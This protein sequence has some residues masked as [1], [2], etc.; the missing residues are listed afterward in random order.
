M[1]AD[2]LNRRAAAFILGAVTLL[3]AGVG[4]ALVV[5]NSRGGGPSDELRASDLRAVRESAVGYLRRAQNRD[6]GFGGTPGETSDPIPTAWAALGLAG[7]QQNVREA[8][9]GSRSVE[10]YLERNSPSPK[11][12]GALERSIL[13]AR[14]AGVPSRSLRKQR[15]FR[16]LVRRQASDGSF[17]GLTN[18][19]AFGVLALRAAGEPLGSKRLDRARSWLERQQNSHGGFG[20]SPRPSQ[21]DVDNTAAALQALVTGRSRRTAIDKA[22]H[23]LVRAQRRDGG[24]GQRPG[25]A[26]NAQSTSWAVQGLATGG[27]GR[28]KEAISKGV[29]YLTS[30]QARDGSIR[31]SRRSAQTP[32]WVTGQA[33]LALHLRPLPLV[34]SAR[35][36]QQV[37]RAGRKPLVK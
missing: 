25:Q 23:F 29:M 33:L 28:P 26:S 16:A 10:D 19:T 11:D 13:V 34:G 37:R 6:G 15:P 22:V 8:P 27:S 32:V 31:Y 1:H 2:R 36:H 7:A 24:F 12:S 21:S 18:L 5:L 35:I 30:L 3:L 17:E 20:F 4:T 9:E 14:A